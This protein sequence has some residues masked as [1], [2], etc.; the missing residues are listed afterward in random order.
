M[1]TGPSNSGKSNAARWM[2]DKY[3]TKGGKSF[4]DRIYI[5][6]PTAKLDPTWFGVKGVRN[7]DKITHGGKESGRRI[8]ETLDRNKKRCKVLGRDKSPH[9][10]IIVDDSVSDNDFMNSP[11]LCQAFIA[12]RHANVSMMM[13]TQSYNKI[14]RTCRIN[15]T[16]LAMFPSK[17]SEIERLYDEHGPI[18]LNKKEFINMVQFATEKEEGNEWPFLFLNTDE[19][20]ESRFRKNL[21]TVLVIDQTRK[22]SGSKDAPASEVSPDATNP[23][24]VS[25]RQKRRK[26]DHVK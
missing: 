11:G 5:F 15:M 25:H 18:H 21:D 4:F 8:M 1:F 26:L 20:E 22:A 23:S 19:P 6:S 24:A 7:S 17:V 2:L 13:L 16:A 10:L 3:Y 9:E 12:G 14:P